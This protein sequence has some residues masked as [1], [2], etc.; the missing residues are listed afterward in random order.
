MFFKTIFVAVSMYWQF[1]FVLLEILQKYSMLILCLYLSLIWFQE[2]SVIYV[3][4]IY[5][6]EDI[7]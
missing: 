7:G 6:F 3:V 5:I 2:M 4:S 1:F